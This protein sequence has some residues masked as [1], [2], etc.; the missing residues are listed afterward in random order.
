MGKRN[1]VAVDL[2]SPH[3]LGLIRIKVKPSQS[4]EHPTIMWLPLI[5]VWRRRYAISILWKL[6][7]WQGS[8][9]QH[10]AQ[11]GPTGPRL[12]PCWPHELCYLGILMTAIHLMQYHWARGVTV[13]A[14]C[15]IQS[16]I[17]HVLHLAVCF[18][19][20]DTLNISMKASSLV[21]IIP[22]TQCTLAI[23]NAYFTIMDSVA[24]SQMLHKVP[25]NLSS[26]NWRNYDIT[27]T[28]SQ[29]ARYIYAYLMEMKT[30][31]EHPTLYVW[32]IEAYAPFFFGKLVYANFNAY[33]LTW[34]ITNL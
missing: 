31:P 5:L 6:P 3:I 30:A 23:S 26:D 19:T 13:F 12:A 9:G 2:D 10:G 14:C 4:C 33:L 17:N 16:Y 7:W 24:D 11:L 25:L 18:P 22:A 1:F 28:E 15:F 27:I 29:T 32:E 34:V 20:D 21:C 8:W